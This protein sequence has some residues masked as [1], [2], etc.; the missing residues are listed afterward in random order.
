MAKNQNKVPQGSILG[1]LCFNIY[2]N[3]LFLVDIETKL[4]NYADD[5]TLY[6]CDMSLSA[7]VNRLENSAKSVT[8]WF[9]YNY[10]K[11]NVN[12][13]KLIISGDKEKMIIASV[14]ETKIIESH[15]VKLLG[16][17]IDRELKLNDNVDIRCKNAARKLNALMRLGNI[18]PLNKWRVLMKAFIESQ[19]AYAPLLYLFH[20]RE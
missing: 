14:S 17:Y 4:C 3:D 15:K 9:E 5:N 19:F 1:P 13:C 6:T 20:S 10:L 8:Q 12:K 16:T 2:L 11:L 18:L 7:L